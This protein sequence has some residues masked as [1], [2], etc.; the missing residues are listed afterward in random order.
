MPATK[1]KPFDAAPHKANVV[2]MNDPFI[3]SYIVRDISSLLEGGSWRWTS[4]RP[5]MRMYLDDVQ[6][7]KLVADLSVGE[8]NFG[9]T[10]PV[11]I[12]FFVNGNLLDK[13]RY[14][15]A[16]SYHFEKPIPDAWLHARSLN[17]L[18]MQPDK[19]W[20]SATDVTYGFILTRA[21]F[22]PI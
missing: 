11:S 21:G 12:S 1:R 8:E 15:R 5:E 20:A 14:G 16:G 9:H 2:N 17:N 10:G 7:M 4:Q 13:V 22:A 6:G 18:A 3:S 19:T